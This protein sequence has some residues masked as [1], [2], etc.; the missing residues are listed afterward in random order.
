MLS[1]VKVFF[2]CFLGIWKSLVEV[3]VRF[4]DSFLSVLSILEF[5][6]LGT[7]TWLR[8]LSSNILRFFFAYWI[9]LCNPFASSSWTEI[10]SSIVSDLNVVSLITLSLYHF[11]RT[12]HSLRDL[13]ESSTP[14]DHYWILLD[15]PLVSAVLNVPHFS[16][17]FLLE[18]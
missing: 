6:S 18:F 5:C 10:G 9:R 4:I 14:T 17:I 12:M 8:V 7:I 16:A 13:F 3:D 1:C 11:F 2:R 15:L